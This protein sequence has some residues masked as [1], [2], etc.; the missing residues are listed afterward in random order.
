MVRVN[1]LK[2]AKFSK[3]FKMLKRRTKI[4]ESEN[5]RRY[6]LT[7]VNPVAD[8]FSP[9]KCVYPPKNSQYKR[10]FLSLSKTKKWKKKNF[11][12]QN[13]IS[14]DTQDLY[15]LKNLKKI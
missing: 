9:K 3:N 7:L 1:P 6:K 10:R 14:S 4:N 13:A 8:F 15:S 11:V 2:K 5:S 12:I